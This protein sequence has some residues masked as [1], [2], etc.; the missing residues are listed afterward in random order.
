LSNQTTD[1]T[2]FVLQALDENP[3]RRTPDTHQAV[4]SPMVATVAQEKEFFINGSLETA[5]AI[6]KYLDVKEITLL[7]IYNA[8]YLFIY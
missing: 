2:F 7:L 3:N 4:P 8:I 1:P 6:C 5:W